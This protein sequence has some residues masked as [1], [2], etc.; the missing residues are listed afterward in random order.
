M[1]PW[2][3]LEWISET[4]HLTSCVPRSG[5]PKERGYEERSSWRKSSDETG[6]PKE[7][8]REKVRPV[9]G[10]YAA[11]EAPQAD[12]FLCCFF[13]IA[14]I[15]FLDGNC[16]PTPIPENNSPKKCRPNPNPGAFK[17]VDPTPCL[18]TPLRQANN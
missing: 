14:Q 7:A 15:P 16:D 3:V 11:Q 2:C 8:P 1:V 5:K 17:K 6:K 13:F 18:N 4:G 10:M 12:F 9:R